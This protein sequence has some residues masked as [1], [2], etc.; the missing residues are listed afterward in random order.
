MKTTQGQKILTYLSQ[1]QTATYLQLM[2]AGAGA[3]P[4]ARIRELERRGWRFLRTWSEDSPKY[5]I[6]WLMGREKTA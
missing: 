3:W 6:I 5:R 2:R 1:H 4:H